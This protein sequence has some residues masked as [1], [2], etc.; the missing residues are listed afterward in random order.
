MED[1]GLLSFYQIQQSSGGIG[2]CQAHYTMKILQAAGMGDCNSTQTPM[3][4]RLK[5]SR[6]SE[7]EEEEA[8]LYRKLIGSLRYL[9]HTRPDLIFIVGYLSRFMQRPTAEHIA[10]SKRVLR[11]VVGTIDHG[12]FYHRGSGGAKLIGYSDSDYAD[13]IDNNHSTSGVV[14]FFGSCLVSWHSLKQRVVTMSSCEAEYVAATSTA[15]QGVWLAWLLADLKQEEARPVELRVDNKSALALIKNYVFHERSKHI[16]VRYHY[17]RQCIEEGSIL[18]EFIS[19]KD[20]LA[21]IGTKTL[22]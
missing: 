4:E 15:T 9:V 8:T 16:R 14:F 17:V 7:A 11:Y 12:C 19:T 5:L 2:L 3:E 1:L 10:A 22:G 21:D 18:A 20:Q 13:D 6:D